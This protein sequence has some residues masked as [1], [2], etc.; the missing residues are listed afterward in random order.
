MRK[1][2]GILPLGLILLL[3]VIFT[4]YVSAYYRADE[5]ALAALASDE[6]VQVSQLSYGWFF[7]G[8]S[9]DT[10]LIFYPGAKVE[11]TAYA[12]LLHA[13]AAE[14]MDVMLVKMPFHLA[15]FGSGRADEIRSDYS[16]DNWF[17]GGHSL[18][19]AMAARYAAKHG[20]ELA[21]LV[22]C[23]AYPTA[24]LDDSL[25]EILLYGSEDGVLN[26]ERLAQ[27]R[28]YAPER[29]YEIELPGGNHAQFGSYGVQA[30]DGPAGI[31]ARQQQEETVEAILRFTGKA[32][33]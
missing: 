20:G 15:F 19:G 26:R 29:S 32:A 22:L 8:P 10:A 7:D 3:A 6:K 24:P 25:V 27:G 21:G 18:G 5:T 28:Q 2:R 17:L 33:A 12:P 14:G 9:G 13:L 1:K 23:A 16:Y 31:S 11:E 30:G 4:V